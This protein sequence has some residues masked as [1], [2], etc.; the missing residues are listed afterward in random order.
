MAIFFLFFHL[1]VDTHHP[2]EDGAIRLAGGDSQS[3]GRVEVFHEG[4]WGTVCHNN[5]DISDAEVVCRQLG[6]PGQWER[7]EVF[8]RPRSQLFFLPAKD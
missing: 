3:N 2:G 4:E 8:C 7:G 5:W 6:H 1:H